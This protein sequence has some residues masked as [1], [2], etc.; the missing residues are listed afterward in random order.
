M[1]YCAALVAAVVGCKKHETVEAK[2]GS[3]GSAPMPVVTVDAAKVVA[4]DE[5]AK[6]FA[7]IHDTKADLEGSLELTLVNGHNVAA[8]ALLGGKQVAHIAHFAEDGKEI[9]HDW[10]YEDMGKA[11]AAVDKPWHD[12]QIVIAKDDPTE[13]GN[14]ETINQLMT[15]FN[16]HDT[17]TMGEAL[18]DKVV[19]S[20]QPL[21]KDWTGRAAVVKAHDELVKAISNITKSTDTAWAAGDYVVVQGTLTGTNDGAAPEWGIPKA[22]KKPVTLKF[23][24]LFEVKAGKVVHSWGYWNRLELLGK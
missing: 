2:T 19:W 20:E 10:V 11:R 1:L 22:T 3:A 17:D 14:L 15:A 18:D 7:A 4:P 13:K 8:F 24:Q 12:N 6:R 5:I 16:D 23:A 21:A 9:D